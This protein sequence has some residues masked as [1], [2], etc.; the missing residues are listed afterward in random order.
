MD[1]LWRF[2]RPTLELGAVKLELNE[3]INLQL[4]TLWAWRE[5]YY[6]FHKQQAEGANRQKQAQILRYG[7]ELTSTV[8]TE[9]AITS[10]KL[11]HY[12]ERTV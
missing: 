6:N 9:H 11:Q 12:R 8:W 10:E 5:V 3:I 2:I 1:F 7:K 4:P